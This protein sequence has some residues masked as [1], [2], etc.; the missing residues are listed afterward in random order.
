MTIYV[1][2]KG[3]QMEINLLPKSNNVEYGAGDVLK[4]KKLFADR[5]KLFRG[6]GHGWG[7][8]TPAKQLKKGD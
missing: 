6:H 2:N 1:N 7:W 8:E 4:N 3:E 5:N